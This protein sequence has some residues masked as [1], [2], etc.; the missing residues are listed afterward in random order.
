MYSIDI[1]YTP[2]EEAFD[3]K[4]LIIYLF[5]TCLAQIVDE[6]GVGLSG[7][8]LPLSCFQICAR[9]RRGLH[10]FSP[11]PAKGKHGLSVTNAVFL[12]VYS[13]NIHIAPCAS[14]AFA[15]WITGRIPTPYD[16]LQGHLVQGALEVLEIH[17]GG[18]EARILLPLVERSGWSQ[19]TS[20]KA[21]PQVVLSQ[22]LEH[23]EPLQLFPEQQE[24][25]EVASHY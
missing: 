16:A 25:R 8:P 15:L 23:R 14:G 21:A 2:D 19:T 3:A 4:A 11:K 17:T 18:L 5:L 20:L 24:A 9:V 12:V 22:Y 6:L 13:L 10:V 1:I 7:Y